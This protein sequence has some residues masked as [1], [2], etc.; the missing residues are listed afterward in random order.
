MPGIRKLGII[1]KRAKK[2]RDREYNIPRLIPSVN[3]PV[4]V[5]CPVSFKIDGTWHSSSYINY[6]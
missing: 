1:A 3:R 6:Y 5:W 4:S 2:K